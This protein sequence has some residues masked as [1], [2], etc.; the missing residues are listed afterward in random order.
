MKAIKKALGICAG[1]YTN[2]CEENGCPYEKEAFRC[3]NVLM[4]DALAYIETLEERLRE[5]EDNGKRD[6]V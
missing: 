6:A 1:V 5:A 3:T 4:S 2:G